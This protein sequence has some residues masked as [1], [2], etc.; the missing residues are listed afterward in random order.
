MEGFKVYNIITSL[1]FLDVTQ[2]V[3]WDVVDYPAIRKIYD[4]IRFYQKTRKSIEKYLCI[5]EFEQQIDRHW[6]DQSVQGI[7]EPLSISIKFDRVLNTGRTLAASLITGERKDRFN[8]LALGTAQTPVSDADYKLYNE[9][10][11]VNVVQNG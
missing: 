8:Y 9:V 2:G 6:N 1:D 5:N 3:S 4:K 10:L 7:P 11:R